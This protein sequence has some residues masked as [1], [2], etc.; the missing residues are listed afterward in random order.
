MPHFQPLFCVIGNRCLILRILLGLT[1][2]LIVAIDLQL[3][4]VTAQ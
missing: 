1:I 4:D 2:G 3:R